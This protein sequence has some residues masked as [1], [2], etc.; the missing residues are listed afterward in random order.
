MSAKPATLPTTLP[1]IVGVGAAFPPPEPA[2]AVVVEAG[3]PPAVPVGPPMPPGISVSDAVADDI[4]EEVL[5]V[6][7]G[8]D[9]VEDEGILLVGVELEDVVLGVRKLDV[10]KEPK[11]DGDIVVEFEIGVTMTGNVV[12]PEL[13]RE[14]VTTKENS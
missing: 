3:A 13:V 9:V 11:E 10:G 5:M 4:V 2:A 7:D 1:T 14:G 8:D 6:G 12:L